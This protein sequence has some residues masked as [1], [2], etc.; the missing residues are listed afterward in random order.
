MKEVPPPTLYPAA[1]VVA[2]PPSEEDVERHRGISLGMELPERRRRW[3]E[4]AK[5]E[6]C[7]IGEN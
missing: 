3:R 2:P 5:E 4:R 7:A 6:N 1:E